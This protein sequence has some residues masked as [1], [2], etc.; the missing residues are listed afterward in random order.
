MSGDAQSRPTQRATDPQQ[1]APGLRG[2]SLR[3]FGQFARLRVGSVK[4]ALS[5]PV[6][7]RVTQ[8]VRRSGKLST[9]YD[10]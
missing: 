3:V 9:L 5:R 6:H 7:Q 10:K 8:A 2:G 1:R 4:V